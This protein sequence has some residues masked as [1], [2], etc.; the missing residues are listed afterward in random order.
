MTVLRG[1][2]SE[3]EDSFTLILQYDGPLLVTVKTTIVTPMVSQP[4]YLIRGTKGSYM[5]VIQYSLLLY[6]DP[7]SS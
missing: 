3:T 2:E 6:S 7:Q 5:K 1:I 4:K